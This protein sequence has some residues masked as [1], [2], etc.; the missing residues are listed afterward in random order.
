MLNVAAVAPG[1]VTVLCRHWN[2]G[3]GLPVPAAVK[4]AELVT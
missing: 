1:M 4:L 2:V 3:E